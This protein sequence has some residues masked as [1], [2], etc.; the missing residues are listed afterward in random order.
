MAKRITE[1]QKKE[2][3][4][5]FSKGKSIDILSEKFSC[6]KLTIIRN[7][8]KDLGGLKYKELSIL[9]KTLNNETIS[10]ESESNFFDSNVNGI[11]LKNDLVEIEHLNDNINKN[12]FLYDSSFLEI[13]P[14]DYEIDEA[15]RKEFSSIPISDIDFPKILYMVVDKKIELE[16]KL[17]KDFPEWRFLPENDLK[18]KTIEVYL[19]LKIAKRFCNKDQKVIKVP[20]PDVFK[21]AAPV[22][23]SRGIS[24]IVSAGKL[25]AL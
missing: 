4:K 5:L 20:N 18:R 24:R 17:L 15:P 11:T 8:K 19:D 10:G 12:D 14:L 9:N 3:T 13:A 2:I 1:N 6:T 16:I 23:I 25:I 22:L 21:I 7:L